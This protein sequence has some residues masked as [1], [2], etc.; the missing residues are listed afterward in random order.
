M[1]F[2]APRK[3]GRNRLN[4]AGYLTASFVS[5]LDNT[6]SIACAARLS[7][8]ANP[9]SQNFPFGARSSLSA[10][11]P[12][13]IF[14]HIKI[15]EWHA[16]ASSRRP[17]LRPRFCRFPLPFPLFVLLI[18]RLAFICA[19]SMPQEYRLRLSVRFDRSFRSSFAYRYYDQYSACASA[20]KFYRP[21]RICPARSLS[22]G[23]AYLCGHLP[24]YGANCIILKKRSVCV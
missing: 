9:L 11:L 21:L 8:P 5:S 6:A 3:A 17:D 1:S 13:Y 19:R 12:Y 23:R 14:I 18:S 2:F 24:F 20:S 16:F 10:L 4:R 7:V 22:C 15:A